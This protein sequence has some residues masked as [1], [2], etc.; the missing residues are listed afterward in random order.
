MTTYVPLDPGIAM[1]IEHLKPSLMNISAA[2]AEAIGTMF[3]CTCTCG[4]VRSIGSSK[5][6]DLHRDSKRSRDTSASFLHQSKY[7]IL[8][9]SSTLEQRTNTSVAVASKVRYSLQATMTY[10][11]AAS[12]LVGH[13]HRALV[14]TPTAAL[15]GR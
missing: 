4:A 1:I 13:G 2:S 10:I 5:K 9:P 11:S 12:I 15:A 6:S 7:S 3:G 8:Y 14:P